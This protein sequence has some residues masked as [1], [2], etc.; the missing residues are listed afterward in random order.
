M[1]QTLKQGVTVSRRKRVC[2]EKQIFYELLPMLGSSLVYDV[3]KGVLRTADKLYVRCCV[4][5]FIVST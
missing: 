4:Y 2:G 1:T 3:H 5:M